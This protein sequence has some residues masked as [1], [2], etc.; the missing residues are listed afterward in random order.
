MNESGIAAEKTIGSQAGTVSLVKFRPNHDQLVTAGGKIW[1]W[2][3][4]PAAKNPIQVMEKNSEWGNLWFD[5]TGSFLIASLDKD[6]IRWD[7]TSP[8]DADPL[9]FRF[10]EGPSHGVTFEKEGRWMAVAGNSTLAF[11]PLTHIYPCVLNGTGFNGAG[12]VRFTPDG[13]SIVAGFIDDGSNIRIWNMPG[14]IQGSP[15]TL[16]DP[17]RGN[18]TAI[19]VDPL[20][21][22]VI[23]GLDVRKAHLLSLNDG[24]AVP[25]MESPDSACPSVAFSRDGKYAAAAFTEFGIRIWDLKSQTSQVLERSKGTEFVNLLFSPDG[26]LFS[27]DEEGTYLN[28]T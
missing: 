27:G 18:V 4:D 26:D 8:P 11:F 5:P 16:W 9:I 12:N 23:V 15:R 3:L 21:Q 1:L 24:K 22:S 2:P 19:D 17:D 13:K 20:G 7:L 10:P 14:E 25:L 6:L 28:G